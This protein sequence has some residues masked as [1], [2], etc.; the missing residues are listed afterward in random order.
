MRMKK[1]LFRLRLA[2]LA[3]LIACPGSLSA[4]HL[5]GLT[6]FGTNAARDQLVSIDPATGAGTVIG[7]FNATVFATGLGVR[8]NRLFLF[9]QVNDRIREVNKISGA[10]ISS[11]NIG[12]GNLN[13]E[14]ALAFRPSDR[15]GF[16]ASPLDAN[17]EPTNDFFMFVI[18]PT[19]GTG[20]SVRLGSTGVAIDAMAFN[21]Q[22][23]LFAI[24]QSEAILYTINPLTG[25]TTT[26][27]PI[28][29]GTARA[30]LVKNSPIAGMAIGPANP[31]MG[32]REEIYAAINDVLYIINPTNGEARLAPTPVLNFGPFVSSISGLAFTPGAG[33]LGN[34]SGRANVGT[35]ERVAINGFQVRGTPAKRV[36]ARGIGP[37]MTT[38]S[39]A[40]A[41]PVLELFNAQG[42]SIARN[43][44]WQSSPNA[45]RMEIQATGLAPGNMKESAI[46]RTLP[47]GA[48]TAILS[49]AN[50]TT[51][52]GLAELYDID[53][54]SG[55]RLVNLSTRGF[56]Q[57][58]DNSLIAGLI[59]SGSAS[60]RVVARAI[61][62]SLTGRGVTTALADPNLEVFNANG[63]SIKTNDNFMMDPDAAEISTRGLAPTNPMEAATI[64]QLQPGGYTVVVR[65]AGSSSGIALAESYNLTSP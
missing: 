20:T 58:G 7:P 45:E 14:G 54:G 10:L 30:P 63:M 43:D 8:D 42:Q 31:D 2:G 46:L 36:L 52:I 22:G 55:S 29:V 34:M 61:G 40:L 4:A 50:N 12:V 28:A 15:V 11:I 27:G 23:T 59:I 53:V 35:G 38:V 47:E 56:V 16:L 60:Q 65:G 17:S 33:T 48:Y 37:T 49:G 64:V 32:N 19:A 62:P 5:T 1:N 3:L 24:G 44:D 13:G 6:L 39:N 41:D 9:D 21:S 51:G 18:E 25:A 57:P 26:V